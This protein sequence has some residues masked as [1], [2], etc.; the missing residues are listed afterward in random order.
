MGGFHV[1]LVSDRG[2]QG[3]PNSL[4]GWGAFFPLGGMINFAG[5]FFYWVVRNLRGDFN[6]SNHFQS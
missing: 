5:G 2:V 4:K 1:T 3:F 6:H